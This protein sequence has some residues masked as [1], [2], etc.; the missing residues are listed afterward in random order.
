M[1]TDQAHK[2]EHIAAA[3]AAAKVSSGSWL[4]EAKKEHHSLFAELDVL[5]KGLD[6]FFSIENQPAAKA[7]YNT[8]NLIVELSVVREVIQR[9][10]SI[11]DIVIPEINRNA[12]WFQRFAESKLM[13]GRKRDAMRAGMYRQETPEKSIYV[14]YDMFTNFKGLVGDVLRS[15]DIPYLSFKNFGTMLSK[16]LRENTHFNPFRMDINPEF[17]YID[18]RQITEIVRAIPDRESKKIIS[19]LYLHLFR[20]LRYMKTMD[21]RSLTQQSISCSLLVFTLLKSEIEVFRQYVDAMAS[22]LRE[23]EM[24][25]LVQSLSYQIGMESKRVFQQ[26]LRDIYE[27]KNPMQ[28]RGKIE[29]GRGILKNLVE[30]AIIQL[31]KYWSHEIK[32]EA[33]FEVFI[34]KTAQSMK[35]REDM[36]VLNRLL[37]EVSR[38]KDAQKRTGMLSMLM[39]YMDYFENFT[40][41]LLRYDDYEQFSGM[42]FKIRDM[43]QAGDDLKKLLDLCHQF[44]IYLDTT[45]RAIGQRADLKERTL[46]TD[47]AEEI[48]KQYLSN[49]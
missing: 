37:S 9:V 19:I 42:F 39:N 12:Y 2:D 29:S 45:L 40:F 7:H 49:I 32:G 24:S 30:Q 16:E 26:E 36:Y 8:K 25:M 14:L 1:A 28:L 35:L 13:D 21:H 33:I 11:L 6:R 10:L 43:F 15:Q 22:K 17:D 38:E 5:L 4:E 27:R 46:D 48:V 23:P 34:T 20:L 47:R 41:K 44:N 3:E 18:N 31:S